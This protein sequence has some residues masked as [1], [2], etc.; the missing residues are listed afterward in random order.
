MTINP[1]EIMDFKEI[2]QKKLGTFIYHEESRD[3]NQ[4]CQINRSFPQ[5]FCIWKAPS[6]I[7]YANRTYGEEIIQHTLSEMINHSMAWPTVFGI[8]DTLPHFW[9]GSPPPQNNVYK[10][11][12]LILEPIRIARSTHVPFTIEEDTI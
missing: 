10:Q 11:K 1:V 4:Y 2:V 5:P 9:Q 6:L 12:R 7:L 8:E 3:F